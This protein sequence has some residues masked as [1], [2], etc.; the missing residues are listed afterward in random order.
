MKTVYGTFCT[1]CIHCSCYKVQNVL[2][3]KWCEHHSLSSYLTLI[4]QNVVVLPSSS[5][6]ARVSLLSLLCRK[7]CGTSLRDPV[8]VVRGSW[9]SAENN[10]FFLHNSKKTW[11]YSHNILTAF[12][13]LM[14]YR[15]TESR[16][17]V[18][19]SILTDNILNVA[20]L[21]YSAH[22][23]R[24]LLCTGGTRQN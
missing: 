6:V 5:N 21:F 4:E 2:C 3:S 13:N 17:N 15:G 19:F 18:Y 10:T 1:P 9:V 22:L 14:K 8:T 16:S 11:D 20:S 12:L 24:L 23:C 7:D